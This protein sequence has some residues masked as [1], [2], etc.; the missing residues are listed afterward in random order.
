MGRGNLISHYE[1]GRGWAG[2]GP[3]YAMQCVI[4]KLSPRNLSPNE[5]RFLSSFSRIVVIT[6][7]T[8]VIFPVV[9]GAIRVI[10]TK[11]LGGKKY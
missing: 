7:L 5:I 9:G 2:R 10:L 8:T 1:R 4:C 11:K 3:G 6:L